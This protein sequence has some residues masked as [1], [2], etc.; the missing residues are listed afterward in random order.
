[1]H[2]SIRSLLYS[3]PFL[4]LLPPCARPLAAQVRHE[5]TEVHMA[6][7][8]RIVLHARDDATARVAATAAFQRIARLEDTFSDYRPNSE[9]RRLEPRAGSWIAVSDELFGVLQ[10]A[11]DVARRTDGAFDPTVG[12]LVA[13]WREARR[14]RTLPAPAALDSARRLVGWQLVELDT[15]RRAVRLTRA[16]M[17]LDLGGIAKGY[18][19][20]AALRAVHECGVPAA[21]IEAG[22]D[23]VV[24]APPPGRNGWRIDAPTAAPAFAR[25]ARSLAHTAIATSGAAFQHLELGG[26][27][28]S[29]V[30]DTRTGSAVTHGRVARVIAADAALADA[31][32]TALHVDPFSADRL[33]LAF[34]HIRIDIAPP[35]T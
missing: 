4:G 3:V 35:E 30:I 34:P 20:Q 2:A 31:L 24:G 27:R 14:T 23:V 13:L 17:R 8:V 11:L 19:L 18:I 33:L 10:R 32:A 7:P 22:G 16:G 5:F 1:V 12:P 26:A 29:H 15:T 6:M 21:L 28:Y 9:L 25:H